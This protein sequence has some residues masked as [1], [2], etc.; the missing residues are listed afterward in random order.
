MNALTLHPPPP[1]PK[2][3]A[4][5][6][7]ML[8]VEDD[9][10]DVEAIRRCLRRT[11]L[12]CELFHATDGIDALGF[13]QARQE[14]GEP[15]PSVILVDL[16]M[17]RMNGFEFLQALKD[18]EDFGPHS[19]FVFSTSNDLKDIELAYENGATGYVV[20]A[21]DPAH[22]QKVL[23]MVCLYHETVESP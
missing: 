22:L 11:Q 10:I 12:A 13:L 14:R 6:C 2:A 18:H 15:Q 19:V 16:N 4:P 20:K 23:T 21:S 1:D 8:V 7:R 17:P 5:V 3:L 9:E